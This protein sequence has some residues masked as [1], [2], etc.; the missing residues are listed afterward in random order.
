MRHYES[1]GRLSG[2]M[3]EA[4]RS[5]DWDNLADVQRACA[6]TVDV[7]RSL[8]E[9]PLDTGQHQRKSTIIRKVLAED[10]EVRD[11]AQ[12]RIAELDLLLRGIQAQR[13]LGQAYR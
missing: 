11:L 13:N 10:A 7:L 4:A 2:A 3:L 12:P 6:E 8:P 5:G 9:S 1:I